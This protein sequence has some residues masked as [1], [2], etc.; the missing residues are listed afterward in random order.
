M[1]PGS[2][3]IGGPGIGSGIGGPG[4]GVVSPKPVH[5]QRYNDFD[6]YGRGPMH[7]GY[8]G[9]GGMS[10]GVSSVSHTPALG[11]GYPSSSGTPGP[12]PHGHGMGGHGHQP[13]PPGYL[14][15]PSGVGALGSGGYGGAAEEEKVYE[16]VIELMDAQSRESAL[17]EL[18]KKREQYEELA[19]VLWHSFGTS[20]P[21]ELC[22]GLD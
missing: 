8:G 10:S 7:S 2:G 21:N 16:L 6:G 11:G 12:G 14:P 22:F 1:L 4:G 5:M 15:G 3:G 17:L 13:V 19:L 9:A 20:C 18:S